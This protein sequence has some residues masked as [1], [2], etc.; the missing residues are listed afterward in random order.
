M[1]KPHT[2]VYHA[3]PAPVVYKPAHTPVYHAAAPAYHH[4]PAYHRAP[5]YHKAH[6]YAPKKYGYSVVTT[7]KVVEE[8]RAAPVE[9]EPEV[10]EAPVEA[11]EPATE[12]AVKAE[13]APAPAYEA[14]ATTEAAAPAERYYRFRF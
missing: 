2:P 4:A 9:A 1:Y 13:E 7:E 12:A 3:A 6:S 14:P 5:V 8:L 10:T 11:A